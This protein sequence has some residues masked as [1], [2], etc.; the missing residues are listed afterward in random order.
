MSIVTLNFPLQHQ[1][2]VH[3][4]S[5]GVKF[6]LGLLRRVQF[7][8]TW[9]QITTTWALLLYNYMYFPWW[10]ASKKFHEIYIWGLLEDPVNEQY[11]RYSVQSLGYQRF[12][13]L[14]FQF[15]WSWK[16]KR[17]DMRARDYQTLSGQ[18]LQG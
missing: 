6:A 8:D 10:T 5:P 1:L 15:L 4:T 18:N 14:L 9:F 13:I 11:P 12:V 3:L 17:K 2:K 16:T 7:S